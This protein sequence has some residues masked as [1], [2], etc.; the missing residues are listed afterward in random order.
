MGT[1]HSVGIEEIRQAVREEVKVVVREEVSALSEEFRA[2]ENKLLCAKGDTKGVQYTVKI[3]QSGLENIH[4]LVLRRDQK[5]YLVSAAHVLVDMIYRQKTDDNVKYVLLWGVDEKAQ[6]LAEWACQCQ[7]KN[8]YLPEN[9]VLR[10]KDDI[11]CSELNTPLDIQHF[12]RA[13]KLR[14]DYLSLISSKVSVGKLVIGHGWVF[15][16]GTIIQS[17]ENRLM[18]DAPSVPGSSDGCP[19]F[20]EKGQLVALVLGAFKH[21]G[22]HLD[23]FTKDDFS[24]LSCIVYAD[25]LKGV[26][27]RLVPDEHCF[28]EWLSHA[29][30]VPLEAQGVGA[31][32]SFSDLHKEKA[33]L[34]F[35]KMLA[36]KLE[37][38]HAEGDELQKVKGW[39]EMTVNS[40]MKQLHEKIWE[41]EDSTPSTDIMFS[42]EEEFLFSPFSED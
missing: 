16:R 17:T 28:Y 39:D 10:G 8:L 11:A 13:S 4:G 35:L 18:V 2:L 7:L 1:C 37:G 34:G 3:K 9:Y 29:E 26:S 27:M 41:K 15:L 24:D 30:E 40:L 32:R 12:L 6:D 33:D 20:D 25:C 19:L 31:D 5:L 14:A 22:T 21:R 42:N 38:G 23:I 36:E